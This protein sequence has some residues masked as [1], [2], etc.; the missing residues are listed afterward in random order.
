ME[1]SQ[2]RARFERASAEKDKVRNELVEAFEYTNPN[3]APN[4]TNGSL[5]NRLMCFDNTAEDSAVMRMI[6]VP[7]SASPTPI[8]AAWSMI[9]IGS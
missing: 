7:V 4:R 9:Q 8:W 3:G 5:P 6:E 2:I 1:V